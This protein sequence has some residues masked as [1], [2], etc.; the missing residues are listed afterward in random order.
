MK[1]DTANYKFIK[2]QQRGTF[3]FNLVLNSIDTNRK[4]MAYQGPPWCE[5]N[6]KERK[7]TTFL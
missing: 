4:I 2:Q 3:E 1:Q 6:V 5:K 7:R